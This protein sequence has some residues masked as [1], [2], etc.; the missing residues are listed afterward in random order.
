MVHQ[1]GRRDGQVVGIGAAI[2]EDHPVLAVPAIGGDE[3]RELRDVGRSNRLRLQRG[4]IVDLAQVLA[5]MGAERTEQ[6]R[7]RHG[8]RRGRIRNA[9]LRRVMAEHWRHDHAGDAGQQRRQVGA[10]HRRDPPRGV[11]QARTLLAQPSGDVRTDRRREV[12]IANRV[13][14]QVMPRQRVLLAGGGVFDVPADGRDRVARHQVVQRHVG[15]VC[16][17]EHEDRMARPQPGIDEDLL[18]LVGRVAV[19]VGLRRI[20]RSEDAGQVLV[21]ADQAGVQRQGGPARRFRLGQPALLHQ[22]RA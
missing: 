4:S 3:I 5:A 14:H 17:A 2:D 8:G 7:I 21:G 18:P 20:G 22:D 6:H 1:P 11:Q 13:E 15:G 9:A 12:R 10:P 19:C 16:R